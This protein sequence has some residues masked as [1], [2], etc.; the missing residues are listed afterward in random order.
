MPPVNIFHKNIPGL[1]V[2]LLDGLVYLR[3]LEGQKDTEDQGKRGVLDYI[4]V[5]KD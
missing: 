1:V 4:Q 3:G 2:Q 5:V